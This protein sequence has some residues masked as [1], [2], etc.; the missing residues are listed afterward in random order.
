MPISFQPARTMVLQPQD[1]VVALYLALAREVVPYAQLATD[2][3]ISPSQAHAAVRRACAAELVRP[4]RTAC[5]VALR[6]FLVH[7]VRYAFPMERGPVGRGYPTAHSAPPLCEE[8]ESDG[9]PLVWPDPDGP[10]RG[11]TVEPLHRSATHA[12]R[13]PEHQRLYHALA[14]IDAIRGGRTRERRRAAQLLE[15]MLAS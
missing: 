4:D 13:S 15:Q 3:G 9:L 12:A 7:G 8:I 1:V 5:R 2:L 14:L 10:V 11:E 6:E